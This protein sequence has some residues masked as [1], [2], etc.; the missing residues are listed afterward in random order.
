MSTVL[1]EAL[2]HEEVIDGQTVQKAPPKRLHVQ[3]QKHLT[4]ELDTH[5][6]DFWE[7]L[8]ELTLVVGSDRVVPDIT[9]VHK[10][11][12]YD[13]GELAETPL[14]AIEIMSPGQMM[15]E[16]LK[17]CERLLQAGTPSCWIFRPEQ[18]KAWE[19]SLSDLVQVNEILDLSVN[20]ANF[21]AP[22]L[23]LNLTDLW[24]RFRL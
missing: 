1:A 21:S 18:E 20:E 17:R 2:Y 19:Y 23:K 12:R 3:F 7:A 4:S 5:L 15:S 16:V 10:T 6:P 14:V 22:V 9:V 8:P 13:D 24:A 11:A